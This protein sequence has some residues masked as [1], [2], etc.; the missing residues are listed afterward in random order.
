M[1]RIIK[2]H[3]Y[4]LEFPEGSPEEIYDYLIS[5]KAK[6]LVHFEDM[7]VNKNKYQLLFS[8]GTEYQIDSYRFTSDC[9]GYDGGKE[10]LFEV[11]YGETEGCY[12]VRCDKFTEDQKAVK[13][14]R[15]LLLE[16]ELKK[17]KK[18]K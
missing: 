2:T 16:K 11:T 17:L 12:R 1:E 8:K 10:F 6:L 5:E 14:K 13:H 3:K 15:I 4:S 9:L 7:L 18:E